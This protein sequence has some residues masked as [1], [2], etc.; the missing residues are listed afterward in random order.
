MTDNDPNILNQSQLIQDDIITISD[1]TRDFEDDQIENIESITKPS[2]R[3]ENDSILE[4]TRM[5]EESIN[6]QEIIMTERNQINYIIKFFM[7]SKQNDMMMLYSTKIKSD[8]TNKYEIR[9]SYHFLKSKRT[10]P[11]Y[12]SEVKSNFQ[13]ISVA[14]NEMKDCIL[15]V[16]KLISDKG[17][18]YGLFY[19]GSKSPNELI[20]IELSQYPIEDHFTVQFV[21]DEKHLQ[22]QIVS[23]QWMKL[24]TVSLR[25]VSKSQVITSFAG[26][27]SM[28]C[29]AFQ[30]NKQYYFITNSGIV[31]TSSIHES[32]EKYTPVKVTES[33]HFISFLKMYLEY[34]CALNTKSSISEL[35][36]ASYTGIDKHMFPLKFT[37]DVDCFG[38]EMLGSG[39]IILQ[40]VIYEKVFLICLSKHYC[41]ILVLNN[42]QFECVYEDYSSK[43]KYMNI[44]EG[45]EFFF[46][47]ANNE[48]ILFNATNFQFIS[49]PN[50]ND[51]LRYLTTIG[52]NRQYPDRKIITLGTR[53]FNLG[54]VTLNS[55]VF[56]KIVTPQLN[57]TFL[58]HGFYPEKTNPFCHIDFKNVRSEDIMQNIIIEMGIYMLKTEPS[59]YK[60]LLGRTSQNESIFRIGYPATD[61]ESSKFSTLVPFMKTS[62]NGHP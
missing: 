59:L 42:N 35:E 23:T 13:L 22:Y 1:L 11:L 14:L 30:F 36:Q 51:D 62:T 31:K 33:L 6:L 17:S 58:S 20:E 60:P 61:F 52:E 27:K 57:Y 18:R 41:I 47:I 8:K 56:Q 45:F 54:N 34:K 15:F 26:K 39:P 12:R 9:F 43:E 44:I 4:I 38:N 25:N 50:N 46:I 24:I 55:D 37:T 48:M 16:L 53:T 3:K 7:S 29:D 40:R 28:L 10:T 32:S 21:G 2:P 19:I 49:I 5:K